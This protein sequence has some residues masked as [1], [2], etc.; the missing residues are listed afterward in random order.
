MG[1]KRLFCSN[2]R[3]QRSA[4]PA[5]FFFEL[6]RELFGQVRDGLDIV[7]IGIEYEATVVILVIVRPKTGSAIVFAARRQRSIIKGLHF[8][9]VGGRKGDVQPPF[10]GFPVP[11]QN[12]GRARPKPA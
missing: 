1:A 8:L 5:I 11:I 12:C 7:A 4:S 9:P 10:Q 2:G 6:Y 3:R